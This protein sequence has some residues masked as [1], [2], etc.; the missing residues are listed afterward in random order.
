MV[1]NPLPRFVAK[2]AVLALGAGVAVVAG[3]AAVRAKPRAC[4]K[5]GAVMK[6]MG[7]GEK[8]AY[9]DAGE[10]AE[11]R[12]RSIAHDVWRCTKCHALEKARW[13]AIVSNGVSA[14]GVCRFRTMKVTGR[15]RVAGGVETNRKCEHCGAV[16]SATLG[17]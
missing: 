13:P 14:C 8:Q 2:L 16:E 17:R 9:L 11:E 4:A 7:D 10:K 12:V 15:Q 3:R 6:R 1:M 5:C